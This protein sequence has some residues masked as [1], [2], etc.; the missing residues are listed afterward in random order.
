MKIE[1]DDN[2]IS[3]TGLSEREIK[4]CLVVALYKL[5]GIHGAAA[6]RLL[7]IS[8]FEFHGLLGKYGSCVN[9]GVKEFLEDIETIKHLEEDDSKN[10]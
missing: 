9:Y 4:E 8:E 3:L 1:L 10:R 5:S 6:G 2:I 7:N